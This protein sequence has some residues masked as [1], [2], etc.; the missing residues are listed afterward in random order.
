ME[1]E[2]LSFEINEAEQIWSLGKEILQFTLL[3]KKD[4]LL[5][6]ELTRRLILFFLMYFG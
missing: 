5:P 6:I 3:P 4:I 2:I 1:R